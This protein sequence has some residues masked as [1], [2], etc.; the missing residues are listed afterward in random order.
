MT[1]RYEPVPGI[2]VVARYADSLL[3]VGENTDLAA[4]EALGAILQ[5][6]PGSE[7]SGSDTAAALTEVQQVLE[8]YPH[9]VFA[10]L[11]VADDRAQGLLRGPVT[12]R[13]ETEV[14]PASGHGQLGITVPFT[15]SEAV[16]VGFNQP[17]ANN[18]LT[19]ELFDLE[20]GVVPGAGAWVHP[21]TGRRH[22]SST[23]GVHAQAA[24]STDDPVATSAPEPPGDIPATQQ[25]GADSVRSTTETGGQAGVVES[26]DA[27]SAD[28]TAVAGATAI[29]GA[30]GVAAAAGTSGGAEAIGWP[31]PQSS[32]DNETSAGN[33]GSGHQASP[34]GYAAPQAGGVPAQTGGVPAQTGAHPAAPQTG[35]HPAPGQPLPAVSSI[36]SWASPADAGAAG[37]DSG[38]PQAAFTPASDYE[39]V[40]LRGVAPSGRGEPLPVAETTTDRSAQPANPRSYG[41]IVFEDGSTFA[42]DRDYVVGRRPEK[43]PRVQSGQA[44]ALTIVDPNTVLSSA[45]ALVTIRGGRISLT[46]LGSLNGTHIAP[47]GALDWT[48][49]QQHQEAPITPG[50]RLLFGWTVATYSGNE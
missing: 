7:P 3:W 29:A 50:T 24:A 42:L 13:N 32:A 39:R 40:D 47:P 41:A 34:T 16:Y 10:A 21:S 28:A 30:A 45:H 26:P 38:T 5:L 25:D 12:V 15:M 11:I 35:G 33:Q 1:L 49:L 17:G 23:T 22:A 6:E 18:E 14:A 27:R 44:A 20:G 31:T 9:T 4:W 48:R 8:Q 37:A 43:D 46:D 19:R 2:G 36:G